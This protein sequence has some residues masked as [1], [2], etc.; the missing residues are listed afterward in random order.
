MQKCSNCS[1]PLQDV[2][3][4]CTFCGTTT[5][6][7]VEARQA[8]DLQTDADR[9][10]AEQRSAMDGARTR[11]SAQVEV[12]TAGKWALISSLVGSVV[13]CFVPVGPVL[14]IVFGLRA[15]RLSQ[16]HGLRGA[17]LGTA[18]LTFGGLGVGLAFLSW[19]GIG[20]MVVKENQRK[21]ELKAQL[22]DL[23][24][25]RLE[26]GAACALTELEMFNVRYEAYGVTTDFDCR[27]T[28]DLE[29]T[30]DEAVLRDLHFI[31]GEKKAEFVAC[32]RF[33]NRWSVHQLRFDDDCSA[34]KEPQKKKKHE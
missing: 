22:G 12:D 29:V 24:S 11:A 31:N 17:A 27:A 23:T 8:R 7:G 16:Q 18:G 13:C 28:G 15:R 4:Q 6:R 33:K 10:A 20:A 21:N 2:I 9:R 26:L 3:E 25:P 32:L 14:G 34:P 5:Q 30:G 1:A 19:L